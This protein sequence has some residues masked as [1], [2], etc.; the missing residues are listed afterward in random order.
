[1]TAG[2]TPPEIRRPENDVHGL[3]PD[4]D[5]PGQSQRQDAEG[6]EETPRASRG[7]DATP[8]ALPSLGVL[9]ASS[10][11]SVTLLPLLS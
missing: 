5:R 11:S 2:V 10:V 4:T 3:R 8:H 7:K 1:M 9:G 6:T